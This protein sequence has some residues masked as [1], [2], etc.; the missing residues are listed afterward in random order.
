M[1][2]GRSAPSVSR[3][4][5]TSADPFLADIGD[6]A[7]GDSVSAS[8][9]GVLA[10][11]LEP[12]DARYAHRV[13]IVTQGA[14]TLALDATVR[15]GALPSPPLASLDHA[16]GVRAMLT[17]EPISG[18]PVEAGDALLFRLKVTSSGSR[19]LLGLQL[20]DVPGE[21]VYPH[22]GSACLKCHEVGDACDVETE[23]IFTTIQ[24]L[25]REVR[26][27]TAVLQRAE[28]VG[29]EVSLPQFE[30][31]R[32]GITAAVEARALIHSFDY[33]RLLKRAADGQVAAR[34]G[35]KA[36]HDTLAEMGVRRRGLTVSLVLIAMA[37]VGLALKIRQVDRERR[38]GSGAGS[39]GPPR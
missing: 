31:K 8:W 35:L 9:R 7:P 4:K 28:I 22:Q 6:L 18:P 14:G 2:D 10:P 23:K 36:G 34:N 26:R 15:P 17:V 13:E 11:H 21:G 20:R 3:G 19:P 24:T 12:G 29:M 39:L 27:A 33:G 1:F 30:L 25:D 5:V 16:S 32:Q 37:L 38:E